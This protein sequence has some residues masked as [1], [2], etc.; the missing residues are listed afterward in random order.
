MIQLVKEILCQ[1]AL[2]YVLSWWEDGEAS[3][4]EGDGSLAM[5]GGADAQGYQGEENGSEPFGGIH[6][7]KNRKL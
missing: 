2:A 6:R 3:G 1:V 7:Y 4:F 5:D